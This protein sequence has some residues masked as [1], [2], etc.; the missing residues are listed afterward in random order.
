MPEKNGV[1]PSDQWPV[2]IFTTERQSSLFFPPLSLSLTPCLTLSLSLS[3]SLRLADNT[4]RTF[5]S[6][7]SPRALTTLFPSHTWSPWWPV[8]ASSV[9]T[10][11]PPF[12]RAPLD[13]R[14]VKRTGDR[15]VARACYARFPVC[16]C[17][18]RLSRSPE[19]TANGNRSAR[20]RRRRA[21]SCQMKRDPEEK[22]RTLGRSRALFQS[23]SVS[24]TLSPSPSRSLR[25]ERS[26]GRCVSVSLSLALFLATSSSR[27]L[28][29][30][31]NVFSVPLSS[32]HVTNTSRHNWSE[33]PAAVRY[34]SDT[35]RRITT[36]SSS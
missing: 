4:I 26:R 16:T 13:G 29:D 3:L 19:R 36:S 18:R 31:R 10:S 6:P 9:N 22:V 28:A 15:G 1:I 12:L 17:V 34:W 2:G 14:V 11:A 25:T 7:E 30:K 27:S 32:R 5:L 35:V 21:T 24:F 20:L 23:T 8:N 33:V